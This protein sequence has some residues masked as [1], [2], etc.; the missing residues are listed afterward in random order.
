MNNTSDDK[1]NQQST[2]A[3]VG[4][5]VQSEI[6]TLIDNIKTT[7]PDHDKALAQIF[8]SGLSLLCFNPIDR[9]AELGF[10]ESHHSLL[11]MKIFKNG[12]TCFWSSKDDF[13]HSMKN[14][15]ITINATKTGIG[16]RYENGLADDEDF[17]HMP[18]LAKLHKVAKFDLKPN[19]EAALSARVDIHDATFYTHKMSKNKAWLYEIDDLTST[20]ETIGDVYIGRILGADIITTEAIVIEIKYKERGVIKTFPITL[21]NDGS[22]YS[23]VLKTTPHDEGKG[24]IKLIYDK[25]I[26]KPSRAPRY[27]FKFQD[28]EPEWRFCNE[29]VRAT[30]FACESTGGGEGQLP[31]LPPNS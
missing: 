5:E 15:G 29:K 14:V 3:I 26:E 16:S 20:P 31:I 7:P 2:D 8:V 4:E 17:G 22:K 13:G 10:V 6:S 28:E 21:P 27:D 18:D 12:C 23:I 30:Q 25:I 1:R 11:E 24:H 9:R 19:A